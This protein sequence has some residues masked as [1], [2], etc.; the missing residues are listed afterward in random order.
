VQDIINA[1][2]HFDKD[3]AELYASIQ[4]Q[5]KHNKKRFYEFANEQKKTFDL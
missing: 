1:I 4:S 5:L 3:P 2:K